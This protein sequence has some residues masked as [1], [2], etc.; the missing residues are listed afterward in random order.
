MC[1]GRKFQFYLIFD[2]ITKLLKPGT[3]KV[4]LDDFLLDHVL[5]IEKFVVTSMPRWNSSFVLNQCKSIKSIECFKS[6]M[7]SLEILDTVEELSIKHMT[8]S[9][10][11]FPNVK[12]LTVFEATRE[13][14]QTISRIMTKLEDITIDSGALTGLDVPTLKKVQLRSIDTRIDGNFFVLHNQIEELSFKSEYRDLCNGDIDDTLLEILTRNLLN[15]KKLEIIGTNFLTSRAFN[16]IRDNCKNLKNFRMQTA[17]QTITEDNWKCLFDING[18]HMYIK[19]E[20]ENNS[21]VQVVATR[22]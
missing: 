13:S 2:C 20:E 21:S 8:T 12:K 10:D 9:M 14:L 3:K 4:G 19:R 7:D 17:D 16:I 5:T 1:F 6:R 18:L 15:V 11:C 22:V